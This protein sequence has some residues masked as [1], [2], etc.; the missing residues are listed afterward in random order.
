MKTNENPFQDL[1]N[2]N[3]QIKNLKLHGKIVTEFGDNLNQRKQ[4]VQVQINNLQSNL[5][6]NLIDKYNSLTLQ[7]KECVSKRIELRR[8]W[9]K[10]E[11]EEMLLNRRAADVERSIS[12]I[13][14]L[15]IDQKLKIESMAFE[16]EQ[17]VSKKS[18]VITNREEIME[19][20][21]MLIA[22]SEKLI[23]LQ[24]K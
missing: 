14:A 21:K 12:D 22:E 9:D 8:K 13:S 4:H 2:L 18:S 19:K 10:L 5:P 17:I 16:L 3:D 20:E 24:I 11:S 1:I 15:T 23:G 6:D 7:L